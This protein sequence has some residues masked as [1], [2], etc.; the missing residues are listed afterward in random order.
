MNQNQKFLLSALAAFSVIF[1]GC[2]P[3]ELTSARVYLNEK[4]YEKAEEFLLKTMEAAPENA[5]APALL[6][7]EIY[8]RRQEWNKMNEMFEIALS[9]NP[10]EKMAD[11]LTVEQYI[12]NNRYFNWTTA[13]N[14]AII[15]YN[16]I[17]HLT[18]E[19]RISA[20]TEV[21]PLFL[22]S[23]N[24]NPSESQTYPVLATV[25]FEIGDTANAIASMDTGYEL[26]PDELGINHTSGQIYLR[27]GQTEKAVDFL[28]KA[29]EL[30]PGNSKIIRQLANVYYDLGQKEESIRTFE[31]AISKEE[32]K[33]IKADL[34]YNLGIL[35]MEM[36]EF[37]AAEDNFYWAN[38]LNPDDTEALLR[39]AQTFERAEKWRKAEKFY[40]ELIAEDPDVK[41]YFLGMVRV[42]MQQGKPDEAK[43]YLA[44]A[45]R[46]GD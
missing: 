21:L 1:L 30:D 32:D 13:F 4:N 25:Y 17:I 42:L 31:D 46:L 44:K 34:Y 35:N 5:E 26:G 39:M 12:K 2:P 6:G 18:G 22:D 19:E 8:G 10:Q 14:N 24:M 7:N 33:T 41:E 43:R 9:I 36:G 20:M 23:K 40:R 29:A 16:K 15:E 27:L 37:D 38:D 45:N 11:G 28:R 3:A